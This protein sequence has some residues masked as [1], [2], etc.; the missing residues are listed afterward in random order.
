VV[1]SRQRLRHDHHPDPCGNHLKRD[2]GV[3]H[4]LSSRNTR[5]VIPV[6]RAVEGILKYLV[7]NIHEREVVCR[8]EMVLLWEYHNW[9]FA[10]QL[11]RV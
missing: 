3:L 1:Q 11:N 7:G 10:V 8:S 2:L 5:K 6:Q 9:R 4:P